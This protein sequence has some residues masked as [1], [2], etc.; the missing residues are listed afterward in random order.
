MSPV[1]HLLHDRFVPLAGLL[2]FGIVCVDVV[3]ASFD[4]DVADRRDHAPLL[5]HLLRV[6]SIEL[7]EVLC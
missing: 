3:E 4:N 7:E 2:F 5:C 6:Y 1:Q